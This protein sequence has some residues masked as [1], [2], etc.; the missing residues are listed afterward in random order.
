MIIFAM[1]CIK[2]IEGVKNMFETILKVAMSYYF[3]CSYYIIF[4]TKV[5]N[6]MIL[7]MH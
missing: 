2:L 1:Q 7:L 6:Q 3:Q 5:E 4:V